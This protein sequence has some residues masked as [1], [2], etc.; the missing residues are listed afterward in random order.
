[1]QVTLGVTDFTFTEQVT[2]NLSA[3]DDLVIGQSVNKATSASATRN[4]VSPAG[5]G[6]PGVPRRF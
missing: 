6:A 3:G 4:P 1:V 5:G 2:G